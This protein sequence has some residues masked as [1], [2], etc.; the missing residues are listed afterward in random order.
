M[1]YTRLPPSQK[2]Q[3]SEIFEYFM[4]DQLRI[5]AYERKKSIERIHEN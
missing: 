3:L 2:R 1:L 4:F 5:Y